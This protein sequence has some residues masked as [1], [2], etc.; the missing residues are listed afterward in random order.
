M[1]EYN[2]ME[3]FSID[4]STAMNGTLGTIVAITLDCETLESWSTLL[5]GFVAGMLYL[6]V[7]NLLV[8]I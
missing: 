8:R 3:E 2:K 6:L 7:S 5:V 1:G 4:L